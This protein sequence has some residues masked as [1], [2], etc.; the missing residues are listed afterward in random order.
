MADN[1]QQRWVQEFLLRQPIEDQVW[2][3]KTLLLRRISS[4]IKDGIISEKILEYLELIEEIDNPNNSQSWDSMKNAYHAVALDCVV[5]FLRENPKNI[6]EYTKAID[7]IWRGRM[8]AMKKMEGAYLNSEGMKYMTTLLEEAVDDASVC[9]FFCLEDTKSD[10][11]QKL[12]IY[13]SNV[14]KEL[15][16]PFL[17][18]AANTLSREGES[19]PSLMNPNSTAQ[20]LE[21]GDEAES[22]S[23][24]M[25]DESP[26]RRPHLP[27]PEQRR[28]VSPL[29]KEESIKKTPRKKWSTEEEDTLRKGVEEFGIGDWK[30]ILTKYRHTLVGRTTVNIK[31]KWRN[32]TLSHVKKEDQK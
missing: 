24:S 15:G 25:S 27:T 30:S 2:L 5:R 28:V 4:G 6:L 18:V 14:F 19:E 11:L 3:I 1:I 10:A 22:I 32:M 21:G 16:P 23:E 31:D 20:T 29:R 9:E 26:I 8:L 12:G 13:L 7:R 17:D